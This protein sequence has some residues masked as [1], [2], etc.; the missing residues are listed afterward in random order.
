MRTATAKR[1]RRLWFKAQLPSHATLG[2]PLPLPEPQFLHLSGGNPFAPTHVV[3]VGVEGS[4]GSS[5]GLPRCGPRETSAPSATRLALCPEGE[6]QSGVVGWT[7]HPRVGAGGPPAIQ[8][9]LC[10]Q[11]CAEPWGTELSAAR[12][13]SALRRAPTEGR[14]RGVLPFQGQEEKITAGN[15][16][17]AHQP[18]SPPS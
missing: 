5:W 4:Q 13:D 3:A 15:S 17:S 6:G 18:N 11:V 2:K 8:M 14:G 9:V 12:P 7:P 16:G 10:V 1:V